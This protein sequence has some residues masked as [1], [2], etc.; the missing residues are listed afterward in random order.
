MFNMGVRGN[1]VRQQKEKFENFPEDLQ[2]TQA[3]DDASFIRNVSPGQFIVTS[4][5]KDMAVQA[6]VGNIRIFET[7][8]QPKGFIRGNTKIGLVFEVKSTK[9]FDRH[10]IEIKIDSMQKDGTQSWIVTSRGID[11]FVTEPPEVNKKPIHYEEASSSTGKPIAMEQREQLVPS[12]SSSST[13]PIRQREWNDISAVPQVMDD[14]CRR[15]SKI[16]TRIVG[17][18]GYPREDDGAIEWRKL[19]LVF[20]REHPEAKKWTGLLGEGKQQEIISILLGFKW[21]IQGHSGGN[22]VDLSLQDNVE[23]PHNWTEFIYHVGSSYYCNFY[24]SIRSDCR[25]ERFKR[26]TANRILHGSGPHERATKRR[27]LRRERATRGTLPNEMESVP[28]CSFVG[29]T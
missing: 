8:L 18:D 19:L 11:K 7:M 17:H 2:R 9:Q 10:G 16:M 21:T 12:S 22:K 4:I 28:E 15:I 1:S 26:R 20:H 25:R 3:R 29:A 13:L 14:N 24:Y 27:I 23:V 6:H 5:W